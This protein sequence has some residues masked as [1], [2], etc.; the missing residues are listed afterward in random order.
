MTNFILL[1]FCLIVGIL[2]IV[3]VISVT[4]DYYLAIGII[5]FSYL[6]FTKELFHFIDKRN[7]VP[8]DLVFIKYRGKYRK[9]YIKDV[10]RYNNSVQ[11]EFDDNTLNIKQLEHIHYPIS[12]IIIPDYMGKVAKILYSEVGNSK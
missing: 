7:L 1:T 2:A 12:R 8:G 5:H 6:V 11:L 10:F 4:L 3:T 9:S